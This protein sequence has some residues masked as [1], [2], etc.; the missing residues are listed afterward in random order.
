MKSSEF[1]VRHWKT[2]VISDNIQNSQIWFLKTFSTCHSSPLQIKG[3]VSK[4]NSKTSKCYFDTVAALCIFLHSSRSKKK[5]KKNTRKQN[6]KNPTDPAIK[7][8]KLLA[9]KDVLDTCNTIF[10]EF[11]SIAV[12]SLHYHGSEI[13][14]AHILHLHCPAELHHAAPLS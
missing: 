4:N 14:C 12:Q 3:S 2:I 6:F 5:Q 11:S 13:C 7:H 10:K 8:G 9:I 1:V